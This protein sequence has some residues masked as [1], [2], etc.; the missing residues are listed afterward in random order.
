MQIKKTRVN[1]ELTSFVPQIR[2]DPA[3]PGAVMLKVS[4][5]VLWKCTS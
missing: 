5:I 4:K 2:G 1:F 3:N